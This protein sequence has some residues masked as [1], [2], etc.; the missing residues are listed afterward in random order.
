MPITST[1]GVRTT[2]RSRG[3]ERADEVGPA[4]LRGRA[5]RGDE[6]DD[7]DR[8]DRPEARREQRRRRRARRAARLRARRSRDVPVAA[9]RGR[10]A[11]RGG[12]RLAMPSSS[13]TPLRNWRMRAVP[14]AS[15]PPI[16]MKLR[17]GRLRVDRAA[18]P[19][20]RSAS[21]A[22]RRR[23][24]RRAGF[25][26][27]IRAGTARGRRRRRRGCASSRRSSGGSPTRA[28]R[29]GG[30]VT[31]AALRPPSTPLTK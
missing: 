28:R 6:E 29:R 30:C 5:Q 17:G 26:R 14:G 24:R 21:R 4:A 22:S 18:A 11:R 15:L 9:Q 31:S 13:R 25:T 20:R 16:T 1:N 3:R 19:A 10:V 2:K 8:A 23:R 12:A 27:R 7:A